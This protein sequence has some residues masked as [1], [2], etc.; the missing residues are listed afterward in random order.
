VFGNKGFDRTRMDDVATA[1]GVGKGTLYEYFNNKEDLLV[2][3][4]GVMMDGMADG[5]SG[6]LENESSPLAKLRSL[7]VFLV[8]AME[9]MGEGYRFFLE[10]MLHTSRARND[11]P[12]LKKMLLEFRKGI[13]DIL[14]A[15]VK[16]GDLRKDLNIVNTAATFAAWFDG[17]VFHWIAIPK[18]PSMR[19]M[20]DA[21]MDT[22]FNGILNPKGGRK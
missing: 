14:V 13:E 10:Y 3:A 19:E 2:G 1:A 5:M 6:A 7:T 16:S 9:H 21:Y 20:A 17:A 18:G 22:F 4:M 15:G 12:I 11:F 8:E